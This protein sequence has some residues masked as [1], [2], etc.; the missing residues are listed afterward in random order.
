VSD[1]VF[2]TDRLV[3]RRWRESD[4]PA[5]LAVYGDAEAMR[6]VGDGKALTEA[7][8]IGWLDVTRK[9]YEHRGYGMF[10][11]E[12]KSTPGV[13]GFCGIVHPGNQPEPEIK[14][15]Y[16]RSSWGRGFATE[17]AAGLLQ[18]GADVHGLC[19]VIATTAPANVASHRVLLKVGM[20]RGALRNDPDGSQT[21]LFQWRPP[22]RVA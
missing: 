17:T 4:L 13:I 22:H 21:Q 16:L 6:W 20:D 8:C 18:Y 7:E 15:A 1:V 11:V 3:V 12:Q 9:N 2:K 10:A 5:L 14:Y 19:H